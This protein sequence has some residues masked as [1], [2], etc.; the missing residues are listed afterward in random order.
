MTLIEV[1]L[2]LFLC[3]LR[4]ESSCTE[5]AKR[6]ALRE[7]TLG[8]QSPQKSAPKGSKDLA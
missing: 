2:A 7:E 5:L 4:R 8:A 1:S 6:R 3:W